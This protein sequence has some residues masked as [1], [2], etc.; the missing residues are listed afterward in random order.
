MLSRGTRGPTGN[1]FPLP[2]F[3]GVG[4]SFASG[5]PADT[6]GVWL[7]AVNATASTAKTTMPS[8]NILLV[9]TASSCRRLALTEIPLYTL[10]IRGLSYRRPVAGQ[11]VLERTA[12]RLSQL[13]DALVHVLGEYAVGFLD[14]LVHCGV[15]PRGPVLQLRIGIVWLSAGLLRSSLHSGGLV[16]S[17]G[18]A[19][20]DVGCRSC[21]DDNGVLLGV[22]PTGN[23]Q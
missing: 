2:G 13:T 4:G 12:V 17:L 11:I 5:L 18:G 22:L 1:L 10:Q 6:G 9:F 3:R 7:I 20:E 14:G 15:L 16:S 8:R 23:R 19:A 21:H